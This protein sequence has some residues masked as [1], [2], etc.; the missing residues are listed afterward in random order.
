MS[1]STSPLLAALGVV[2]LAAALV[3]LSMRVLK[4]PTLVSYLLA[5]LLVGPA[6]GWLGA[7]DQ[8]PE[9]LGLLSELG[10]VLLLF[11]VGLELHLQ[12]IREVGKVAVVAGLGQVAFT[13]GIGVVLCWGIGF[14]WME[15]IFLAI[16]LTFSSTAVVV[17]LLGQKKQLDSLHGRIAVGIFLVQ[18]LVVIVMLTFLAGLQGAETL[19]VS[20]VSIGL[21][22][23]FG[24]MVLLLVLSLWGGRKILPRAVAFTDGA[25][26]LMLLGSLAWCLGFVLLAHA[27]GLSA[28][29]GA[30]LAGLA[31]A[32][33][34]GAHDL[35]RRTQPLLYLFVA[36]FF[37]TLGAN[38]Q[39]S[40]AGQYWWQ[41][42]LLSLFVLIGNPVIFIA[43]IARYGYDARTTFLTSVTVAQISE[44][45]FIFA[46]M[47]VSMGAI[48][49]PILSVV[50]IVGVVTFAVSAYMILYAE[51]L[52]AWMEGGWILRVLGAN[53]S[54]D[55][56]PPPA[57]T[58]EAPIIVVGM[59]PLG[60]HV[61]RGLHAQGYA[62]C[63]VDT[64][65]RKL[66]D[67]PGEH[68]VGDVDYPATL[69]ELRLPDARMVVSTLR[70]E[71]VNKLLVWR[72]HEVGVPVAV[73][74][75]DQAMKEQ[76]QQ[77][78][79]T[80]IIEARLT[81]G[82]ELVAALEGIQPRTS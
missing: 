51:R 71:S 15:S 9:A 50:A 33:G 63:A 49:T 8:R 4:L 40:D 32:Q 39:L 44:F 2:G 11:T 24:G 52:Y 30:F 45:S 47:G 12:R 62:V 79:P 37:V 7:G 27:M 58:A 31:V 36:I 66:T 5:G 69:Q 65:P 70:I 73:Y 74:A 3:A 28:E 76:L 41:G 14:T 6:L 22:K 17:K 55:P 19:N 48:E 64:D 35:Q 60:Q 25:P 16:A 68:L 23:A 13:A 59:N 29:V 61:V 20:T 67:L 75:I 43:I 56:P 21:L 34:R 38:M 72:C 1:L 18:D 80:W 46:A 82:E 54:T 53:K 57:D 42:L 78:A 81:A 10:I 77:V 26:A